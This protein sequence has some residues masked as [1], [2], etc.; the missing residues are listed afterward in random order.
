[1]RD[2]NLKKGRSSPQINALKAKIEEQDKKIEKYENFNN[3]FIK[4]NSL[5]PIQKTWW[6]EFWETVEEVNKAFAHILFITLFINVFLITLAVKQDSNWSL[7][8]CGFISFFVYAPILIFSLMIH[9]K[10]KKA[11][12]VVRDMQSVD[13]KVAKILPKFFR[14]HHTLNFSTK[15]HKFLDIR[16]LESI[17]HLFILT[18]LCYVNTIVIITLL[19][20][21]AEHLYQY[22]SVLGT[23]T[24]PDLSLDH[25]LPPFF[26]CL[27]FLLVASIVSKIFI[28]MTKSFFQVIDPKWALYMGSSIL[29]QAIL[30]VTVAAAFSPYFKEVY[31]LALTS[32][33]QDILDSFLEVL[34]LGIDTIAE[35]YLLEEDLKVFWKSRKEV[36]TKFLKIRKFF[37]ICVFIMHF[38][39]MLIANYIIEKQ[40][41]KEINPML[42]ER[43]K[44]EKAKL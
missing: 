13:L 43:E 25:S 41:I 5:K 11:E 2:N 3:I 21:I 8:L 32:S 27:G 23:K 29:V 6:H 36:N 20:T 19:E 37:E 35:D 44:T 10:N 24:N 1:M 15:D 42:E 9:Q 16:N 40:Y 12:G 22:K 38:L 28:T 14:R 34:Q 39:D 7:I 33:I 4:L 26:I 31:E 17:K 30:V 18:C